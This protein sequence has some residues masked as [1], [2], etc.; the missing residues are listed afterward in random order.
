[1]TATNSS[2]MLMMSP[3]SA[4]KQKFGA[5]AHIDSALKQFR[6]NNKLSSAGNDIVSPN[7]QNENGLIIASNGPITPTPNRFTNALLN[8][9]NLISEFDPM[10]GE[11]DYKLRQLMVDNFMP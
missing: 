2:P 11:K 9:G 8:G 6:S 4:V 1:M 3:K 10:S 7:S 5:T